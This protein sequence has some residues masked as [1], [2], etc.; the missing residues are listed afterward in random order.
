MS[1][2]TLTQTFCSATTLANLFNQVTYNDAL[3]LFKFFVEKLGIRLP[4]E[5]IEEIRDEIINNTFVRVANAS[6]NKQKQDVYY[7]GYYTMALKSQM[8]EHFKV[9]NKRNSNQLDIVYY[10]FVEEDENVEERKNNEKK[11]FEQAIQY[12]EELQATNPEI[13]PLTISLF[14]YHY[15]AGLDYAKISRQLGYTPQFISERVK[16]CL[17]ELKKA[18]K[19]NKLKYGEDN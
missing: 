8:I 12:L 17:S 1:S 14:K 11:F 10:D 18:A 13:N 7:K 15:I 6:L 19:Q 5:E 9:Q 4:K 2:T 3:N 16:V